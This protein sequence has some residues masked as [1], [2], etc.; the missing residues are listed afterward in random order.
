VADVLRRLLNLFSDSIVT[1]KPSEF[2]TTVKPVK[3]VI[4]ATHHTTKMLGT[5]YTSNMQIIFR[6]FLAM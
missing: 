3:T 6:G 4:T 1:R 5:A 2:P